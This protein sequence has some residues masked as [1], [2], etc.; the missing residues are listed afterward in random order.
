M[1][2]CR[3][4]EQYGLRFQRAYGPEEFIEGHRESKVW[5]IGLNPAVDPKWVD[6]RTTRQ[7]QEYFD[8]HSTVHSYF[9]DFRT[10]SARVFSAFGKSGGTAHTDLVK[11]SSKGWPPPGT[12]GRDRKQIIKNCEAY[13]I[14]QLRE[15]KPAMIICN[16]AEVSTAVKT[17]LPPPSDTPLTATS[18]FSDI[19]AHRV[20]IV[21]SGF[22]GR[23]DNYAK[24]RLGREIEAQLDEIS[25]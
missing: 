6:L 24:R 13:L 3:N 16:G 20:C 8:D 4:C 15:F 19:E 12:T 9:F 22:V 21:L 23:L 14:S 2:E 11:C 1:H 7:L 5:I 10:V 18:Y 17:M 25:L